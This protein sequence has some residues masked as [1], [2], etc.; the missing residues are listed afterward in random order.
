[1]K[2]LYFFLYAQFDREILILEKD[3][4]KYMTTPI[5]FA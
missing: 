1:M 2:N 5:C 3:R 4:R